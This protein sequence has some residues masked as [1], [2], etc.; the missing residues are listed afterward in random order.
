MTTASSQGVDGWFMTKWKDSLI[1]CKSMS[2]TETASRTVYTRTSVPLK[3]QHDERFHQNWLPPPHYICA[4]PKLEIDHLPCTRLLL[5]S[6]LCRL[7]P[8]WKWKRYS[9]G[10]ANKNITFA[11]HALHSFSWLLLLQ[12]GL[13]PCIWATMNV[14]RMWASWKLVCKGIYERTHNMPSFNQLSWYTQVK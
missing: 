13:S 8:V 1:Q 7:H 12:C 2:R 10:I 3:R 11:L 4:K 9:C 6:A 5:V 14:K